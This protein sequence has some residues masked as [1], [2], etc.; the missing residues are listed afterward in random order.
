MAP[1]PRYQ[2]YYSV[3]SPFARR[4]RVALQRLALDFEPLEMNVFTPSADFLAAAPLGFVPA[5]VIREPNETIVLSDSWVILEYL[6]D[7]YGGKIWPVELKAKLCV[8]A[9]SVLAEGIMAESVRWYLEMQRP[10]PSEEHL[11]EYLGIIDR[12]LTHIQSTSLRVMPWKISD[13]QMTQA[14]YDLFIALEYLQVRMKDHDWF[15]RYPELARF[16][17]LHRNRQDLAPTAPPA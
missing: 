7:Q 15:S 4:I 17:E 11:Q 13:F 10:L 6:N 14:G 1:L 5:L 8:R 9:A 3:R 2:L 12:T 16:V